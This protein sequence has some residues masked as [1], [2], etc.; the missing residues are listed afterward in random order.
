MLK[1]MAGDDSF[2]KGLGWRALTTVPWAT[3]AYLVGDGLAQTADGVL[4]LAFPWAVLDLTRSPAALGVLAA[5]QYVPLLGAG[6]AGRLVDR[7]DPRGVVLA[8]LVLSIV[9]LGAGGWMTAAHRDRTT[10]LYV[11]AWGL[12]WLRVVR[13]AADR[14]IVRSGAMTAAPLAVNALNVTMGDI[15]WYAAPGLGGLLIAVGGPELAFVAAAAAYL[16]AGLPVC[17]LPVMPA[18]GRDS[19]SLKMAWRRLREA[20]PVWWG[21]VTF[22]LWTST[23]GMAAAVQIVYFRQTLHLGASRVGLIGMLSGVLPVAVGLA[24]PYLVHRVRVPILMT[25]SLLISAT[26][27]AGL[28]FSGNWWL[29]TLAV[30]ATDGLAGVT[31]LVLMVMMQKALRRS[32]YGQ[33][34]ALQIVV[35]TAGLP[36]GGWLGG[37]V[38]ALVGVQATLLMAGFVT[39]LVALGVWMTPLARLGALGVA[40]GGADS[41]R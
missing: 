41:A 11:L 19:L 35:Q 29:A 34:T 30:S 39:A 8:S 37:E 2:A 23:W 1:D 4:R 24:G 40:T 15:A 32:E 25:A 20:R 18:A 9:L 22:S 5:A 3:R 31:T 12:A 7:R 17:R 21:T 26:G 10:A 28:A 13:M 16:L 36:V 38:A 14:V 33:V 27:M 6:L